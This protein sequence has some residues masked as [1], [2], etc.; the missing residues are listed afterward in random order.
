MSLYCMAQSDSNIRQSQWV[1]HTSIMQMIFM[2]K[3]AEAL[4]R[5]DCHDIYQNKFIQDIDVDTVFYWFIWMAVATVYGIW[6]VL[7]INSSVYQLQCVS[8]V[9]L[10]YIWRKCKLIVHTEHEEKWEDWIIEE[11]RRI[12]E[13]N[14][15]IKT[16]VTDKTLSLQMKLWR[17]SHIS[18]NILSVV[19]EYCQNL[20]HISLNII[21]K[22][23]FDLFNWQS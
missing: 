19:E 18:I 6:T 4:D 22:F 13:S 7:T 3:Y 8:F 12:C 14:G 9:L 10:T 11:G 2:T 1:F 17:L 5:A 16:C 21:V 15:S 23:W 20:G